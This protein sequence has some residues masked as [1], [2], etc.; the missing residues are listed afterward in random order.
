MYL[1][2]RDPPVDSSRHDSGS[3]RRRHAKRTVSSERSAT[4]HSRKK[5]VHGAVRHHNARWYSSV[6]LDFHRDVLH[7]HVFLGVQDLLRLRFHVTGV[8]YPH[9]RDCMRD[10]CLHVL[11]AECRGLQM[12]SNLFLCVALTG[13]C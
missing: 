4:T 12:V 1:H 8:C 10:Y 3:Q 7:L 2:I 11:P 6:R 9:D 5:M 13:D